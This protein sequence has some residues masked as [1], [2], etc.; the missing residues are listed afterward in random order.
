M[1]DWEFRDCE[2]RIERAYEMGSL[3][4]T[5]PRACIRRAKRYWSMDVD[6]LDAIQNGDIDDELWEKLLRVKSDRKQTG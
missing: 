2:E 1:E 6:K 4:T 3:F 5:E